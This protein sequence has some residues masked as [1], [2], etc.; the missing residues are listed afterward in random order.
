MRNQRIIWWIAMLLVAGA[1]YIISYFVWF[2]SAHE[3]EGT[4]MI[5][6]KS[7]SPQSDFW[8][9]VRSGAEEAA[10]EKGVQFMVSGPLDDTD[11]NSQ[12]NALQDALTIKPRAVVIA[13]LNDQRVLDGITRL[14]DAHIPVVVMDTPLPV[15]NAPSSVSSD[16]VQMGMQ[17]GRMAAYQTNS[18]PYVAIIGDDQSSSIF[19][20][21]EQGIKQV[22][23]AIAN[24]H[25][26]TYY[27]GESEQLAYVLTNKL[28]DEQPRPNALIVMNEPIAVGAA[29]ALKEHHLDSMMFI[30]FDSSFYE[31]ELL[32]EKTLDA[33]IVQK[34]FNMGY[35]AVQKV[36]TDSNSLN[37]QHSITMIPSTVITPTTMYTPENQKLLFPFYEK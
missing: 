21:R 24:S 14:Q 13:P 33:L 26:A 36:L 9:T 15:N 8:Q 19:K 20:A 6:L 37:S 7:N 23:G 1:I 29:R 4:I 3:E 30:A 5:I 10:K 12:L 35:L 2:T 32:E 28:L 16:H 34:P 25:I 17:A 11:I 27:S 18:A 31:I 22:L